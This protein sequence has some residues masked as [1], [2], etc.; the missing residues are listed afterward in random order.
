[1]PKLKYRAWTDE[2]K[3]IVI[4]NARYTPE[5][6]QRKLKKKGYRRG[7]SYIRA[8]LY[9]LRAR[10]NMK[11]QTARQLAEC[12]GVDETTIT[13]WIRNGYLEAKR[14]ETA[15]S[16][17]YIIN[18]NIIDFVKSYPH[19]INL[20]KVD[21]DW[22]IDLAFGGKEGLGALETGDSVGEGDDFMEYI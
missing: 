20:K 16:P 15:V 12:F 4:D 21:P 10:K 5:N 13:R 19:L 14:R 18:R 11:G 3:Q 17:W 7:L 2:E 1:M 22:F 9:R 8:Q 6:I